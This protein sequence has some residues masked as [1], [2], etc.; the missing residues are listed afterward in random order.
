[1]ASPQKT[2]TPAVIIQ[3]LIVLV[4]IPFLPLLISR[5]W[6]WWEAW[7]Y[8][9]CMIFGFIISRALAARRNPDIIR[10]RAQS[11]QQ[12]NTETWDRVL[13]PTVALGSG[14]IPLVAGLDKLFAWSPEIS[15]PVTL[16]SLIIFIAGYT[17]GIYA[18]IENQFFSGVVRIQSERG[19][20]VVK[21]G[22]YRW[23]RHPGYAGALINYL[24]T[25]LLLDSAWA[26]IPAI[27]VSVALI[28]RTSL[29][30]RTLQE[31]LPGYREYSAQVRY[32]LLPGIW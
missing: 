16:L 14:F 26:F 30:D 1:M 13:A 11:M 7:I 5:R 8:A 23:V 15:L 10:E 9:I 6:D 3:L 25:P 18:F 4:L 24:A 31:K 17:F 27:L 22:P 28:I 2:I 19:H 21:S 29:E 32:R 12:E 20:Q